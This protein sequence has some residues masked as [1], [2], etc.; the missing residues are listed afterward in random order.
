MNILPTKEQPGAL[1]GGAEA[2]F[3]AWKVWVASNATELS[4]VALV[5]AVVVLAG[6][7]T[8]W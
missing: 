6:L 4:W 8:H 1:P 2:S 5:G 7:Y 3:S